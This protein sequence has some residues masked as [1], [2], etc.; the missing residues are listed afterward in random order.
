VIDIPFNSWSKIRLARGQKTATSRNH[1]YGCPGDVFVVKI[2][3]LVFR[4]RLTH[5]E[6][7]SLGFVRDCFY[8]QEGCNS[9]EEFVDVWNSIHPNRGFDENQK[10]WLHVFR[11][12]A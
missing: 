12:D 2:R 3:D 1:R 7:V 9:G 8:L 10:V 4:Y 11:E 5:V 6:R